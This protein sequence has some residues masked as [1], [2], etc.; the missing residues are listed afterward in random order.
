VDVIID[1]VRAGLYTLK[2]LSSIIRATAEAQKLYARHLLAGSDVV[3]DKKDKIALDQMSQ[4]TACLKQ[5]NIY[6][7]KRG[8]ANNKFAEQIMTDV[9]EP[10]DGFIKE[11]NLILKQLDKEEKESRESINSLQ[12][13]LFKD[14]EECLRAYNRYQDALTTNAGEKKINKRMH[15]YLNYYFKYEDALKTFNSRKEDHGTKKKFTN[16]DAT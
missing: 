15:K 14:K 1:Q 5:L 3:N 10:L 11:G 7:A 6:V 9:L 13:Q 8:T 4:H 12:T 16:C 2:R